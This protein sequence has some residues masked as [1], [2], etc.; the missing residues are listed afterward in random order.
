MKIFLKKFIL[1]IQINEKFNLIIYTKIPKDIFIEIKK[2]I[3]P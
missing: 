1:I 3:D 2:I